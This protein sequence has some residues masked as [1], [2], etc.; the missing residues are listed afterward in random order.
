[1]LN[2][3]EAGEYS[4]YLAHPFS[5]CLDPVIKGQV[6]VGQ[7]E[8]AGQSMVVNWVKITRLIARWVLI[9]PNPT[10]TLYIRAS[11]V[12]VRYEFAEIA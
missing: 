5:Q 1:M 12:L 4:K 6:K 2:P 8:R 10:V 3:E 9:D 7:S 11:P